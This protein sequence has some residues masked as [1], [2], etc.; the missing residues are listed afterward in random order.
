MTTHN[1]EKGAVFM[2]HFTQIAAALESRNLDAM[3]LTCE[4]NRF[5]ATGFHSSGTDGAA[6]VTRRSSVISSAAGTSSQERAFR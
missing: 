6:L 4:A 2:N 5:Y 1:A 3:L